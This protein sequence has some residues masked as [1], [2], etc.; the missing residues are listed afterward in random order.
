MPYNPIPAADL[1]QIILYSGGV[2][3]DAMRMAR[4]IC[5][6]SVLEQDFR[7]DNR[8]REEEFQHLVD[9]YKFAF[10]TSELW[11]KLAKI[12][13]AMNKN[14]I[15]TDE[16]LPDLLYKMIVIEYRGDNLWFDLHPAVRR[17]FDQNRDVIESLG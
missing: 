6:K 4:G 16:M 8:A 11:K 9:D 7:I 12:C 1:D 13:T 2:L 15:M 5:K 17:I 3:V 10:E 14:V